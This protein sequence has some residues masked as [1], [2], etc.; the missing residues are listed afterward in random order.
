MNF[1]TGD[2]CFSNS[3]YN[4]LK[5]LLLIHIYIYIYI[6]I[7]GVATSQL[8]GTHI[9]AMRV[10]GRFGT[11]VEWLGGHVCQGQLSLPSFRGRYMSGGGNLRLARGELP[12]LTKGLKLGSYRSR[13]GGYYSGTLVTVVTAVLKAVSLPEETYSGYRALFEVFWH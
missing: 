11:S 2:L 13:P 1:T 12:G 7:R 8:W 3:L 4:N 5:Y 6:C 10:G 9:H